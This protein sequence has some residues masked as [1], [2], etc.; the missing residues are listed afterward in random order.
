M[1]VVC[2]KFIELVICCCIFVDVLRLWIE[3]CIE[4][5]NLVVCDKLCVR[6]EFLV[7]GEVFVYVGRVGCIVCCIGICV[8]GVLFFIGFVIVCELV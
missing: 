2:D 3:F 4:S 7:D 1:L 8:C 6:L 5:D